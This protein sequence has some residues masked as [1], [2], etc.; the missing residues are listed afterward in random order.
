[1]YYKALIIFMLLMLSVP[2]LATAQ[3]ITA[4]PAPSKTPTEAPQA[5]EESQ[6]TQQSQSIAPWTQGDLAILTGNVQRPNGITWHDSKLY[7]VCTGDST[8]YELDDRSAATRTYI[9]GV[10]NAHTLYAETDEIGELSLWVPDFQ[11]GQLLRVGRT[12]VET[13]GE[14]LAGPWGI[15]FFNETEFLVSNLQ[16]NN[17]VIVNRTGEAREVITGLRSPTGVVA[18]DE[19]VYVANNG[20]ARRAIEWVSRSEVVESDAAVETLP[21]V[22]G[23]QSTT[24]MVLADDGY[25]YFTYALGTRGVVGRINPDT[26]RENGGCGNDQ[27]EIVVYTELAAPLAGLSIT[28]DRRLFVHTMFSPDIYWVQLDSPDQPA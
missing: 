16:A 11:T 28:P 10:R 14:N 18:D 15:A 1:M 19:H 8:I 5:E 9:F 7:A 6:D 26:C 4:T 21:L 3:D 25:L 17:V 22:S 12:G 27:V 20:S 13:V 24:G 23:L 2:A